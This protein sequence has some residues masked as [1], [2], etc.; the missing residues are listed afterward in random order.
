MKLK[1]FLISIPLILLTMFI[2][3][4][5]YKPLIISIYNEYRPMLLNGGGEECLT[6]LKQIQA[7]YKLIGDTGSVS[8]PILN[9]VR[10]TKYV[11]TTLSTP[12]IVSCP[13][14]LNV[15][16]WLEDIKAKSIG[17]IGTINCRS[18]RG[19]GLQSEHSFGIAIDITRIDDAVIKRDW[20]KSNT[21][22]KKLKQAAKS[23]CNYFSN[24]LT[25]YSNRL[26]HDHFHLDNGIG[27][28]CHAE[29][30]QNLL[31]SLSN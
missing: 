6:D 15:G 2:L 13:T 4:K 16:K 11:N 26:H 29:E 5:Y 21:K 17:H 27:F 24:V 7:S 28:N 9:A 14:A 8:C 30:K 1:F 22:G 3:I 19:S 12:F 20:K 25:P 31:K 18:R 23:A 10:V